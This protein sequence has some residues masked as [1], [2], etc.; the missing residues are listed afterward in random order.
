MEEK[1]QG[2][3]EK[4]KAS[5]V[6]QKNKSVG[7]RLTIIIVSIMFI[8]FGI[9]TAYD[10][11][12]SYNSA[13]KKNIDEMQYKTYMYANHIEITFTSASRSAI[14]LTNQIRTTL[15]TVD[16]ERRLRGNILRNATDIATSNEYI[17]GVGV[18]FE[19]NVFD[20]KDAEYVTDTN[21]SGALALYVSSDGSLTDVDNHKGSDWYEKAF[22]SQKMMVFGPYN[23]GGNIIV[24]YCSPIVIDGTPLG[25]VNVDV[26]VS[27]L[28]KEYEES[29]GTSK[30]SLTALISN[31]DTIVVNTAFP[32]T[33]MQKMEKSEK[34]QE[35]FD[36]ALKDGK[37]KDTGISS[38]TN[39]KSNIVLVAF[40][41]PGT[42]EKWMFESCDSFDY[43]SKEPRED[44]ILNIVFSI[45][46][47]II[48]AVA[49]MILTK[50]TVTKP[51]AIA[52]DILVKFADYDLRTPQG[53]EAVNEYMDS[54]K[55][56]IA[57]LLRAVRIFHTNITD[58]LKRILDNAQNTAATA[59]E[60]T[61]TAQSAAT[62]AGEVSQAVNNIAQ[63]ASSQAQDTQ[64][65]A[66]S[67][68]N[69]N[70]LIKEM[71]SILSDLNNSADEIDK[72]KNEGNQILKEL[73]VAMGD[74]NDISKLV[75]D[76]IMQTNDSAERISNA[77]D[78]I[79]SISDQT[80]L[81]ALNAAIEAARAGEAGKGFA[82]VAEEIRKLA[83][84]SA[85]FTG[86]IKQTIDEL[87]EKTTKAVETMK[88]AEKIVETQNI[89]MQETKDKFKKISYAVE[90][91]KE[92]LKVLDDS[93][94]KIENE[95]QNIVRAI[96]NLSAIS[97]ENAATTEQASASVETQSQSISDI[98]RA[99]EN[100]AQIA[101]KLQEEVAKFNL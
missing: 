53:A 90:K 45:V 65:A 100:L 83:E 40:S 46:S 26:D 63:G 70:T 37:V 12:I 88:N 101:G 94:Q 4:N 34:E 13:I 85:G 71:L 48:M 23:Y 67:I 41:I 74:G 60:L 3:P 98:S 56:E 1:V 62:S 14:D 15:M 92:I 77:G 86:E 47:V 27:N 8:G 6:K 61:A 30:D 68:E 58:L 89:K 80:N 32:E 31:N 2:K 22:K 50:K 76:T 35:Y 91:S 96:E 17:S 16:K 99:S 79:Q 25:V 72:S 81:L 73:T 66:I 11:V 49:I 7:M 51:L 95:N 84:Q 78:M 64:S 28:Q 59:E 54:N 20:G 57:S 18:Y 10:A 9:K 69:S 44:M 42:D 19:P 39:K 87:K 29:C 97:E 82:V 24:S 52:D 55:N 5:T 43:L 38:I 36:Q 21:K 33:V 75:S 93:S